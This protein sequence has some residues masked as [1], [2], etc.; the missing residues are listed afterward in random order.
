VR[1]ETPKMYIDLSS[2]AKGYA[3]D[4]LANYLK[5]KNYKNFFIEVGGEIRTAGKKGIKDWM[6]GVERPSTGE[7]QVQTA[8]PLKNMAIATSGNYRNFFEDNG[9]KYGH[10][11]DPR[12]G[13]PVEH[14]TLSVSV[15]AKTCM[16]A[17]AWAT[18]LMVLGQEKGLEK[19][20][21]NNIEAYFIYVKDGKT[22]VIGTEG[23]MKRIK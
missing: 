14:Q 11:I 13:K 19:A 5:K 10:T 8:I 18:A 20:L 16:E 15:I 17:D 23:F 22:E 9:S 3:V 21:E 1:K 12:T 7:Q 4:K 2:I 6:V